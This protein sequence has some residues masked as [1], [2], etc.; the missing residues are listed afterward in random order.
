MKHTLYILLIFLFTGLNAQ[1]GS[2]NQGFSSSIGRGVGVESVASQYEPEAEAFFD[3]L[4]LTNDTVKDAINTFVQQMKDSLP[5]E[6]S[7]MVAIY[8]FVGNGTRTGSAATHKYNLLDP[9]DADSSF[10]LT[11]IDTPGHDGFGVNFKVGGVVS[12]AN[13]HI[14]PSSKLTLNNTHVALYSIKDT[15]TETVRYDIGCSEGT[16]RLHV[17][18]ATAATSYSYQYNATSGEGRLGGSSTDAKIFY[19]AGRTSASYHSIYIDGSKAGSNTSTGGSLPTI[20]MYL[21]AQNDDGT[22]ANVTARCYSYASIGGGFSDASNIIY[23]R[24][25]ERLQV[26]LR[27]SNEVLYANREGIS[28]DLT[29][30]ENYALLQDFITNNETVE[31][32]DMP[33]EIYEISQPLVVPS[34]RTIT[35]NATIKMMTSDTATLVNDVS[36]E[37]STLV[38][39]DGSL[40][41]VGQW[42]GVTDTSKYYVYDTWYSWVGEII[43]IDEDTIKLGWQAPEN[44]WADSM[45]M[46][47][48]CQPIFFLDEVNN[49]T[50]NGV[51]TIDG[52]RDNQ[53]QL[54]GTIWIKKLIESF[55]AGTG[56]FGVMA[57]NISISQI[58]IKD[59]LK[60]GI[61][62]VGFGSTTDSCRNITISNLYSK[63]NH[64]KNIVFYNSDS[65]S[66]SN[67]TCDSATWEDG[68]MFYND[69]NNVWINNYSATYN[70]RYGISWQQTNSNLTANN[71]TTINNIQ[72]GIRIGA[73][74]ST[75]TNVTMSDRLEI[76]GLWPTTGNVMNNVTI[77][78]S[79]SKYTI[80]FYS[81]GIDGLT[82]TGLYMNNNGNGAGA[83]FYSYEYDGGWPSDININNGYI[84]NQ[85]GTIS[86]YGDADIIFNNFTGL[87]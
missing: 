21:A 69:V 48:T 79:T 66:I 75:W 7:Q 5:T 39:S 42:I 87:E 10:R 81:D 3:A 63:N 19:V 85:N 78:N 74:E 35:L 45:G 40:F 6:W 46:V 62:F 15:T 54:R 53:A 28:P 38:V 44:Y 51:G 32:G 52:N 43:D 23:Y 16:D 41:S 14:R 65:I 31:I 9:Q 18:I 76:A 84:T 68:L 17:C 2:S 60:H 11:F 36:Q 50:I 24:I 59:C 73:T 4:S 13:T 1:I 61:A 86:N 57:K 37:D 20:D 12:Y 56:I 26:A 30:Q 80:I 67:V 55:G 71:I 77:N 64:D 25:V 29:P 33:T 72:S 47:A 22:K 49:V 27:R 58:N 70:G 34:D 82:I 83:A 8:P